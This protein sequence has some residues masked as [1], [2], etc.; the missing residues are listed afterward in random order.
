MLSAEVIWNSQNRIEVDDHKKAEQ[1]IKLIDLLDDDD[2]VKSVHS[3]FDISEKVMA[4]L[5]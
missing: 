4:E 1:V 3:N 2:E 5:G